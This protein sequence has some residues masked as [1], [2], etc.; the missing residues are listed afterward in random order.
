V[1][2]R[3]KAFKSISPG[4]LPPLGIIFGLFVGFVAAQA[5]NNPERAKAA[6]STEASALRTVI[7]LS[8]NFPEGPKTRLHALIRRYITHTVTLE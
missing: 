3:A 4:L 5:W 7:L 1:G 6:V 8:D 2:E